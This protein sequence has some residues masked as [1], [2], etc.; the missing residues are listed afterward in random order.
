V[1][2]EWDAAKEAANIAKHGV[3]FSE[4]QLAFSD[5]RRVILTDK[6]HGTEE[7]QFFCIG[8]TGRG[9]ADRAIYVSSWRNDSDYRRW[10]SAKRQE[11]L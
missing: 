4:A 2:F 1:K 3:N 8:H 10:I 5:S 6:T 7:P 9:G 11:N